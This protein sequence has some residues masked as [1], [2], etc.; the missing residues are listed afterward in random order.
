MTE[1]RGYTPY[2]P[3]QREQK[4]KEA[5][6]LMQQGVERL[7]TDPKG[8]LDMMARMHNYSWATSG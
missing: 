8:Y 4:T 5:F 6:E 7:I 2:T 3:E 1:R